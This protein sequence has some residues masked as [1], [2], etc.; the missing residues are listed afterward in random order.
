VFHVKGKEGGVNAVTVVIAIKALQNFTWGRGPS[1]RSL[2]CVSI[3]ES[4]I[5][6]HWCRETTENHQ[7]C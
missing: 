4:C 7:M 2:A 5:H 6:R 3:C 1:A